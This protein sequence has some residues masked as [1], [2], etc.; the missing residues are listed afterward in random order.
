MDLSELVDAILERRTLDDDAVIVKQWVNQGALLYDPVT[1][2]PVENPVDGPPLRHTV[3]GIL[4]THN[5]DILLHNIADLACF[6]CQYGGTEI[7]STLSRN[8]P[9]YSE[10]IC[11]LYNVDSAVAFCKQ[12]RGHRWT[13]DPAVVEDHERKLQEAD[14]NDEEE[15]YRAIQRCRD[16]SV[17]QR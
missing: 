7:M 11:H 8:E 3:T 15:F 1:R 4:L 16:G 14:E 17:Q 10:H 12:C 13:D 2:D 6:C 9:D 5:G